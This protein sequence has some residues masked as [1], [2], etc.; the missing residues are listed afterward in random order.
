MLSKA[1]FCFVSVSLDIAKIFMQW[2]NLQSH[3]KHRRACL[4]SLFVASNAVT[5]MKTYKGKGKGKAI[6]LQA[7]TGP[8]GSRRLRLPDFKT[9]GT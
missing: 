2:C 9:I 5:E 7:W 8:E 3:N 1:A 6:P 4:Q